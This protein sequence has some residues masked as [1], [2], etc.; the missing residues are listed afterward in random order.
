MLNVVVVLSVSSNGR[1]R[2]HGRIS[3]N[4]GRLERPYV[5][6]LSCHAVAENVAFPDERRLLNLQPTAPAFLSPARLAFIF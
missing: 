6:F 3:I 1:H 2:I 4:A 5:R